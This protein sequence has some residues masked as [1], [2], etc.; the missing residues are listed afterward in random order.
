MSADVHLAGSR[1][2]CRNA[3]CGGRWR[4]PVAPGIGGAGR[5]VDV[6]KV[7]L[8]E[9]SVARPFSIDEITVETEYGAAGAGVGH[10]RFY[11]GPRKSSRRTE[12]DQPADPA[13]WAN[14]VK[15]ACAAQRLLDQGTAIRGE[16]E[17][18][19]DDG[20]RAAHSH[21]RSSRVR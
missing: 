19:R 8:V 3:G 5:R 18:H 7:F 15:D 10:R 21:R 14:N 1:C 12:S 13:A 16:L 20:R 9:G 11:A 4:R 6:I 17:R 2:N